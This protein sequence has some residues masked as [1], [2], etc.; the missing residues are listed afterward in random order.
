MESEIIPNLPARGK[1]YH[2]T[3]PVPV[4]ESNMYHVNEIT[5]DVSD[6]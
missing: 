5:A 4:W 3:L 2:N 6:Q 1:K